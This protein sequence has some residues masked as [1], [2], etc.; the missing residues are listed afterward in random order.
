LRSESRVW[1]SWRICKRPRYRIALAAVEEQE[2][3]GVSEEFVHPSLRLAIAPLN[4]T[5]N[6]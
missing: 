1:I 5:C 4:T 2:K 6:T 3:P